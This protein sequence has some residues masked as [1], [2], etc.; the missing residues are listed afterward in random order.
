MGTET[1]QDKK[2]IQSKR[3]RVHYITAWGWGLTSPHSANR[4]PA[5]KI[6]NNSVCYLTQASLHNMLMSQQHLC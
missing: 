1:E 4:K 2:G 6:I 5:S 3:T